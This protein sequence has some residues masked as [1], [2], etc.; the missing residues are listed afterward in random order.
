MG[1]RTRAVGRAVTR[2]ALIRPTRAAAAALADRPGGASGFTRWLG[3][4]VLWL[5]P[6]LAHGVLAPIIIVTNPS[7]AWLAVTL[8]YA[9]VVLAAWTLARRIAH[10]FE[11]P[12]RGSA[13]ATSIVPAAVSVPGLVAIVAYAAAAALLLD[14]LG[15]IYGAGAL[16]LALVAIAQRRAGRR[17]GRM[18]AAIDAASTAFH[19]PPSALEGRLR[20]RRRVVERTGID[21]ERVVRREQVIEIRPAPARAVDQLQRHPEEVDAA[22]A[23]IGEHE[24]EL[25]GGAIIL[26]D[27]SHKTLERRRLLS[28]SDGMVV[29]MVDGG[30]QTTLTLATGISPA[31]A[32]AVAAWAGREL[33]QDLVEWRPYERR[34]VVA[35]LSPAARAVRERLARLLKLHPHEL[36]IEVDEVA[37]G[38]GTRIDEVRITGAPDLATDPE[39]RR[40]AWAEAALSLPGGSNGWKVEIDAARSEVTMRWGARRELPRQAP[41]AGLLPG[42]PSD[43]WATLPIG[44]GED[45]APVA[46]DL[47]LGP[48][49]LYVGPTGS[50]KTVGLLADVAQRIARGHDVFI[51]DPTKGGVDFS[52]V[53]P[54]VRCFADTL[55]ETESMLEAIYAEGQRRKRLLKREQEV[56]WSDL[57]LEV[58]ERED[59]R[60]LSV[61]IDEVGSLLLAPS[62]P[63]SLP[64]DDPRRLEIEEEAATRAGLLIMVGKMARELRFVGIH[65]MLALQRPDASILSGELRSNL[66]SVVQLAKPGSPPSLDSLRMIFAGEQ[67][68]QAL[69][70]LRALDDGRS[71]GLAVLAGDGGELTGARIAY[72]PMR[73]IP[74][75][76]AARGIHPAQRPPL[77]APRSAAPVHGRIIEE[78]EPAEEPEIDLGELDLDLPEV[79]F[80]DPTPAPTPTPPGADDFDFIATTASPLRAAPEH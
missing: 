65:L 46:L 78:I 28:S 16:T 79:D 68:Q 13:V 17:A 41:L 54:Y 39:K 49:A 11:R 19:V 5:L 77:A 2:A 44:L 59:V 32:E 6:A 72:A 52:S 20:H 58:R 50:G 74:D 53:L 29:A 73:E 37:D 18:A 35:Q 38:T 31:R 34:A 33:D 21:G 12:W 43:D 64:K 4:S 55:D 7:A 48:H 30:E 67:P 23:A 61:L 63:K 25:R 62:V 47:T 69:D 24:A 56:K 15:R 10:T 80:F 42:A 27:A 60:P 9:L 26:R 14:D 1:K 40:A 45:G 22:L 71:R 66:T 75:L 70:A 76:L 36:A 8:P 3:V 51:A 57:E